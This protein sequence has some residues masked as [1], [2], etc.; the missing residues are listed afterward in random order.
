[1]APEVRG[2]K[3]MLNR[4]R[5]FNKN[6]YVSSATPLTYLT[7][8]LELRNLDKLFDGIYGAPLKKNEHI[9]KI[10]SITKK[11]S[12]RAVYIGDSDMD[13]IYAKRCG[14][15][16]IGLENNQNQFKQKPKILIRDYI[17]F[18]NHIL[19]S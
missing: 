16:F 14:C 9:N 11:T 3:T 7:R 12:H 15:D 13:R 10:L 5:S 8:I 18:F 4:L 2:A 17:S 19:D 1:L 6:I